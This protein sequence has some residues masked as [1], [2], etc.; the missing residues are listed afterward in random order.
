MPYKVTGGQVIYRQWR[1]DEGIFETSQF[2]TTLNDLYMLCLRV[3]DPKMVDRIIVF[4]EDECGDLRE[5]VF[6]FQ[7]MSLSKIG[8]DEE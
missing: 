4:G 1:D 5:L 6:S 7:S 8:K 3:E 2:F